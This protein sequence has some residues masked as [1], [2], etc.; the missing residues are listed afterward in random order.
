MSKVLVRNVNEDVQILPYGKVPN[1]RQMEWYRREKSIFFHFGI[2][3]FTNREWGD[4]TENPQDFNPKSLD[5]RQWM[6]V[7]K[8]AG[9]TTAILTAKH[10]DGFCLWPSK[11]TE[12]SIK[13]SP[14]K[15]GKGDIVKEFTDA[16]AEYGIKAGL[17]LS[18]WDR[19]EKTWG[20]DEYNDF[21]VNQ[22]EE[23]FN[24]YGKI[25]ECWW[26]GA[27]STIANYDFERWVKAVRKCQP[28]AVIFGS[29]GA[30]PYVDVRWVGNENGI[31]GK[32]C[33]AT[34]E[35]IALREEIN[36][37]LNSGKADG[38]LFIPAEVDVSI[39]PGWFYHPE[40]DEQVR[41]P[42]N[43][44]KLW[45]TSVGSN[46]GLLLNVP[47]N[48]DGLISDADIQSITKFN[49]MLNKGLEIN[50][51]EEASVDASSVGDEEYLAENVL[52][53]NSNSFYTPEA[54]CF[55]PEIVFE[56]DEEVEFNTFVLSEVIEFGHKIRGFEVSAKVGKDWKLLCKGQCVGY[57]CAE[58]FE[59]VSTKTVKLRITDAVAAPQ[60]RFFGLYMFD[61]NWFKAEKM[62]FSN[63]N[64]MRNGLAVVE[65][66]G[67]CF[68]VDLGGITPFN[69]IAFEGDKINKYE[70]YIFDGTNFNLCIEGENV[71]DEKITCV[72]QKP[73][74]WSYKFRINVTE[75]RRDID[76]LKI[77]VYCN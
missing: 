45:F 17:Y 10:H 4:G 11:Y 22:I 9:F 76:T 71:S 47:P 64:I 77:E 28:D 46:S 68:D 5:C 52:N 60:I 42:E 35:E 30:T 67:D 13:N 36:S 39:R 57:K 14:Y 3:T 62:R 53:H 37:K 44:M 24:N 23:L 27:G 6:R 48:K 70:L 58:H 49:E 51:A 33:W 54:G 2:N 32:P 63:E 8:E 66:E 38:E 21:Y 72:F 25:W 7:I 18:P 34:V 1:A 12:H 50:L 59:T 56:F 61:E 65:R 26:D 41:S 74:D 40:Q 29:L 19:H 15:D 16:C 43:L 73:I 75:K 31:A 55:T 69:K 20:T